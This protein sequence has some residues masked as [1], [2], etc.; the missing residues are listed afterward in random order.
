MFGGR[1]FLLLLGPD[2]AL[3]GFIH[4]DEMAEEIVI[5]QL[6]WALHYFE[7]VIGK[8][9][10]WVDVGLLDLVESLLQIHQHQ[11]SCHH[12]VAFWATF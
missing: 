3:F 12:L 11:V 1:L 9:I 5:Y 6:F 7:E 8:R 4:F 10:Q 2:R